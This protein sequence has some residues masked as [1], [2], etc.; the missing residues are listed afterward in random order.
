MIVPIGG[1]HAGFELKEKVVGFLKSKGFEVKDYGPFN[2]DSV[3]YPDFGHQVALN[4]ENNAGV[5]GIVICGSGNGINMT[6]NKHQAI[7]SALCW[8]TEIAELAR[9]HNDANIIAIPARF[10]SE[11]LALEMVDVFFSTAFEGGRHQKRV[12]KIPC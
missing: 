9:L 6:V 11:E 8:T 1:D 10:V 5:L 3:D 12:D 2:G 4:V 7:R